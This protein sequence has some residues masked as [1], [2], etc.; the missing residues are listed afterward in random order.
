MKKMLLT[1]LTAIM[2]LSALSVPALAKPS[3]AVSGTFDY[4]FDVE[5]VREANGNQF[6]YATEDEDW[7]GDFVGTGDATFTVG[8]F[9]AGFWNVHLRSEFTGTVLG[10]KEG[11]MIIQL[12]GKKPANEDWY[13]QWV[14]ISGTGDLANARGEGTWGGPGFGAEGPDIWYSGEVHFEP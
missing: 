5:E 7:L 13:G 1:L 11:T 8:I 14:I 9:S 12:V 2:L 4:T 6:L 3:T 10:D